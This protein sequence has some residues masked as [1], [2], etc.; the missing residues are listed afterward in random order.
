VDKPFVFEGSGADFVPSKNNPDLYSVTITA[1]EINPYCWA[2]DNVEIVEIK[3]KNSV[4]IAIDS[5][6]QAEPL[7]CKTEGGLLLNDHI[8]NNNWQSIS[9]ENESHN[10]NA[11][12]SNLINTDLGTKSITGFDPYGCPFHSDD[13]EVQFNGDCPDAYYYFNPLQPHGIDFNFDGKVIIRNRSGQKVVEL[14][15]P[16][17]WDGTSSSGYLDFGLYLVEFPDGS[18]KKLKYYK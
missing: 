16:C 13:I 3:I 8:I 15:C 2:T 1:D 17:K 5:I 10:I 18:V 11:L 14:N 12:S 6:G 7:Q 4:Y 9:I